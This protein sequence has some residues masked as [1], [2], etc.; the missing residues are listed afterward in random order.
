M[1]ETRGTRRPLGGCRNCSNAL[2]TEQTREDQ[3][4][5]DKPVYVGVDPHSH[6]IAAKEENKKSTKKNV[7]EGS[8][9][10]RMVNKFKRT[11]SDGLLLVVP[12]R[13]YGKRR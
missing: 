5:K 11:I 3:S 2:N 4:S 9:T 12:T 6:R 7:S 1:V 8:T 10:P 13:V